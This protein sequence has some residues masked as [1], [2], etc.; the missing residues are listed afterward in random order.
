MQIICNKKCNKIPVK[1]FSVLLILTCTKCGTNQRVKSNSI[2][3]KY[4]F[5]I[6]IRWSMLMHVM[7]R[8]K[9]RMT[10]CMLRS[11]ELRP[12][13][14][15]ITYYFHRPYLKNFKIVYAKVSLNVYYGFIAK[16]LKNYYKRPFCN[17]T[18][19]SFYT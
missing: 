18:T 2:Y 6:P 1:K 12:I 3:Y 8:P 16:E 14:L 4:T 17:E 7:L 5:R 19:C 9:I 15:S 13:S 11:I 10:W